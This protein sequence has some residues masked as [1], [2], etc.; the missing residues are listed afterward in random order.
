[1]KRTLVTRDNYY[2]F[3]WEVLHCRNT[4]TG[5]LFAKC[6]HTRYPELWKRTPRI[7][8]A[9]GVIAIFL[10]L[11]W[12]CRAHGCQFFSP[13]PIWILL[14]QCLCIYW[15]NLIRSIQFSATIY[16]IVGIRWFVTECCVSLIFD[17]WQQKR[18]F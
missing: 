14:C 12:L 2:M 15:R 4:K 11:Y 9:P 8:Q 16:S 3:S 18:C 13:N 1:M 7:L 10:V 6:A 5:V 17:W